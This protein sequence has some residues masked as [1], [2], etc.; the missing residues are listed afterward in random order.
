MTKANKQSCNRFDSSMIFTIKNVGV[1]LMN[2][3]ILFLKA[4]K[5]PTFQ[6]LWPR[7]FHSITAEEK[8]EKK[9]FLKKLCFV[10]KRGVLSVFLVA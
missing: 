1:G 9:E 3:R 8:K 2:F 6:M 4:I 10:L 7:L 5:L